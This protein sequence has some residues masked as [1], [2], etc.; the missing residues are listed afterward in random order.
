VG[1]EAAGLP[2][3]VI[4]AASVKLTIPMPG[5][6]ESLNAAIAAAVLTYALARRQV[7]GA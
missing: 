1:T 2:R 3:E 4:E 6:T 7:T 5:G